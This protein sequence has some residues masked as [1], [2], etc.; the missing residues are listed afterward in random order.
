M[1]NEKKKT[2]K[3][4]LTPQ[5]IAFIKSELMKLPSETRRRILL[6]ANALDE[7]SEDDDLIHSTVWYFSQKKNEKELKEVFTDFANNGFSMSF[8]EESDKKGSSIPRKVKILYPE[9]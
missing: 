3:V 6:I 8:L 9:D 2:Q 7:E 4:G 1:T 5:N